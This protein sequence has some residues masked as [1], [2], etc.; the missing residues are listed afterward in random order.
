MV[1]GDSETALAALDALRSSFTGN[2]ICVPQSPFGSFENL[3]VLRR[4]FTPLTKN[5]VHFL[6]DDFMD[7]ANI[8]VM[9]GEIKKIDV[10][11]K[12]LVLK[13]VHQPIDF[14][15]ILIAWGSEKARLD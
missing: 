12:Q 4:K 8:T 9:Q 14:D 7:K 2:I 3:D 5:E 6:E 15:R 1:L 11:K 10:D 13:N